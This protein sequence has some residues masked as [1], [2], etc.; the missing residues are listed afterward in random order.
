MG[1]LESAIHDAGIDRSGERE[2][3]DQAA[4]RGSLTIPA[5][6]AGCRVEHLALTPWQRTFGANPLIKGRF[7]LP[8]K[9][10]GNGFC[11]CLFPGCNHNREKYMPR[12]TLTEA[13]V[14]ALRPRRIAYDIRDGKLR[15]FGVRVLHSGKKRFFVHCQHRGERVWK[16]IGD[17]GTIAVT[18]A[19]GRTLPAGRNALRGRRRDRVRAL[20]AGLEGKNALCEPVALSE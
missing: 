3:P 12:I 10:A 19:R 7:S 20:R 2:Y 17:A 6:P 15:G 5:L 16:I 14:K 18:E 11:N 9:P 13:R 4:H 1:G 8:S